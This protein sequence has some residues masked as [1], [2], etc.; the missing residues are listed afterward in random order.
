MI[1]ISFVLFRWENDPRETQCD[2]NWVFIA[3]VENLYKKNKKKI[4]IIRI[5]IHTV[6]GSIRKNL[7]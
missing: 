7:W 5:Q 4:Q 6:K 2:E 1:E 3:S